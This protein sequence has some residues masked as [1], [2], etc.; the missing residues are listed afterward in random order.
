MKKQ[1]SCLLIALAVACAP[2]SAAFVLLDDFES[3]DAGSDLSAASS[4]TGDGGVFTIASTGDG[5]AVQYVVNTGAPPK[6]VWNTSSISTSGVTTV[7]F[8]MQIPSYTNSSSTQSANNVLLRDASLT[9]AWGNSRNQ[10]S[11]QQTEVSSSTN[12]ILAYRNGG[13]TVSGANVDVDTWYNFW[14][15]SDTTADEWALYQSTGFDSGV[16]VQS[17]MGWRNSTDTGNVLFTLG[18]APINTVDVGA[19]I[20]NIYYDLTGANT[21]YPF[22]IIPE[23]STYATIAL[24]LVM[25][26]FFARQRHRG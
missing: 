26:G 12:P 23:P 9:P 2:L 24:G 8:Q 6:F 18:A 15:V 11:L 1:F 10:L 22:Q 19:L 7:F 25:L 4:W 3:Y 13:T 20:D 14:V 21:D 17:G 5:K 16:L